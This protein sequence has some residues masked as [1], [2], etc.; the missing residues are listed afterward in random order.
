[1]AAGA[2]TVELARIVGAEHVLSEPGGHY[3]RDAT[4]ARGL[5]GHADWVVTP[6]SSE[7]VAGV[8]RWC[9]DHEVPIVPRGGGTGFAG[10][11]VPQGGLVLSLER[12]TRVR[13]IEPF[14]WRMQVEAGI[15]TAHVRRLARENGL[16]YP[17]DPGAAEQSQIGGNIATNAGGPHAFKHGVTGAW[18]LG[19]EVVLAS[20]ELVQV[21]GPIRKDVTGYDLKSLLVGSEGT[22]GIVTSAWL[23]LLPAPEVEL[24]LAV[25]YP[26]TATGCA[27]LQNV[28]GSG[29]VPSALEYLD[30]GTLEISG[31]AFP[32]R[33]PAGAGFMVI[34][35][36]E[37][38]EQGARELLGELSEV[39][40]D[41]A[42]AA[43]TPDRR[44]AV[45]FWR[46]RHG[47]S[48]AV[49]AKRG[50]KISEDIVVPFERLADAIEA[51]VDAGRRAGVDALSWGHA[52]DGNLHA[53][54]LLAPDDA[55]A[56]ARADLA[57]H[58]LFSLAVEFDGS[59]S[60]EHGIGLVKRDA[61]RALTDPHLRELQL[62][63]KA[64]FDPQGIMNPGKK[65]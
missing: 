14:S 62:Q 7:Q 65:I 57:A 25:V 63:I 15:T 50:G 45:E 1:M 40:A 35:E 4:E 26:D 34:A 59:L 41:D 27:A 43:Y 33:L 58:E 19:L 12:L 13:S 51:T 2:G 44:E 48:V 17:P 5:S 21:G 20:G 29:L 28:I 53:T 6:T 32:W 36:A 54:F 64:L 11:C 23:R 3:L 60:G 55:D 8:V 42:L 49:E 24:P 46:W 31:A 61:S 38:S 22:L 16:L 47:V 56:L 9:G 37:G 10:G 52:G 30:A 18:V 39:L